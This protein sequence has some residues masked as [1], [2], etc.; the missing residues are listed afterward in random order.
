MIPADHGVLLVRW[1]NDWAV[2]DLFDNILGIIIIPLCF[3]VVGF[4]WWVLLR[5][6]DVNLW[7]I[8]S[9]VLLLLPIF[10]PVILF[11]MTY[12]RWMG[13]VRTKFVYENPRTTLRISLPP[14]VLKSPEAMESVFTHI[15]APNGS[16]NLWQAYIDGK[17]PLTASFEIASI[18]G[19]VRFYIN[20]HQKLKDMVES[21]LYAQYPG[22]EVTEEPLDY[23]AEI[24]WNPDEMDLMSFHVVKKNDAIYPIKTYIDFGHDR[25]PKEE[26]KFEPMATLIE[27]LGKA[28]PHERLIVQIICTP[29][30]KTDFNQGSLSKSG[31]WVEEAQ[32][33]INEIL[34]RDDKKLGSEETENRPTLTMGERD[35]V[36]AMERNVSKLAYVVG[37]RC[38]YVT[39]DK[40]QF[41]G[42]MI[43]PML[44]SFKQYGIIGRNE[45][46]TRWKTEFDYQWFQD[47]SGTRQIAMKKGELGQLRAR[48]YSA[49]SGSGNAGHQPKVMSVEE[50]ATIYHIPGR[51][52]LTPGLARIPS[53]MSTAPGN[54]PIDANP[55]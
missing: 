41:N 2:K 22:I 11:Y 31:T 6:V 42:G 40:T 47:F 51:S 52:V 26:E 12:D 37:I 13:F 10:L 32:A 19:D 46:G 4:V 18:G 23:T 55:S 30:A 54:L 17:H 15:Y 34:Q 5:N 28:K 27:H 33:K 50:L 49:G 9:F 24:Q 45:L 38:M 14:E 25:L 3:L 1:Y 53:T 48:S 39:L 21:Q 35:T 44:G 7:P 43:G 20:V 29:H 16:D 8:L 36:T